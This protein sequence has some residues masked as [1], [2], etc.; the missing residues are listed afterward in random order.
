[1]KC[2]KGL[3]SFLFQGTGEKISGSGVW[4]T[5][6]ALSGVEVVGEGV[7]IH[8]LHLRTKVWEAVALDS[9]Y[10]LRGLKR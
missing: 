5:D 1:M 10:G 2:K 9:L 3:K 4:D 8:G 6:N 7:A